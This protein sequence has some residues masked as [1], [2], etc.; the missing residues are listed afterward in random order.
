MFERGSRLHGAI[1]P[2]SPTS[3]V[4][5]VG[6]RRLFLAIRSLTLRIS[7]GTLSWERS[8][9]VIWS[10]TA[11]QWYKR[12]EAGSVLDQHESPPYVMSN[13]C[14]AFQPANRI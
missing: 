7:V 13:L 1:E 6:I 2:F 3:L 10:D 14:Y 11:L 5:T 4:Q 12:D 9:R 8:V